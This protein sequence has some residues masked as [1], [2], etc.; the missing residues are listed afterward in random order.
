MGHKSKERREIKEKIW[1]LESMFGEITDLTIPIS[2]NPPAP[3][4]T[5]IPGLRL[6]L[7]Y[8]KKLKLEYSHTCGY[9]RDPHFYKKTFTGLCA[10]TNFERCKFPR[11]IENYWDDDCPI[12]LEFKRNAIEQRQI[13]E[14]IKASKENGIIIEE[15]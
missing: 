8:M 7:E 10:L 14:E 9:L 6:N 11:I 13:S 3:D 1:L 12:I 5:Y 15:D 2:I 4:Q